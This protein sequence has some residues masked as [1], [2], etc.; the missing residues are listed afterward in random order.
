MV[1]F[2]P[3][4][5]IDSVSVIVE[6]GDRSWFR[7]ENGYIFR[8]SSLNGPHCK[9]LTVQIAHTADGGFS[10]GYSECAKHS[11]H[12]EYKAKPTN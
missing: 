5:E 6:R 11:C 8:E 1:E 2:S 12:I 10:G 9:I 4:Y 3:E 7:S